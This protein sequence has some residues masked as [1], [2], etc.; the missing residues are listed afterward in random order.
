MRQ[1]VR[2]R[3]IPGLFGLVGMTPVAGV[4]AP[5]CNPLDDNDFLGS[6]SR[7]GSACPSGFGCFGLP[8]FMLATRFTCAPDTTTT[9]TQ[10][11]VCSG[12]CLDT[13]G[14]PLSTGCSE[15]FEPI[16]YDSTGS[17]Q[18]D[19]ISMCAPATCY[20][21]NCGSNSVNLTGAP[22]SGHQCNATDSRGAFNPASPANNGDQC[23]FSW[24]FEVGSQGLVRSPTSDTVGLC[25]D[26]SKYG[27]P[28][29]D[30]LTDPTFGTTANPGAAAF[31]CVSTMVGG[32]PLHPPAEPPRAPYHAR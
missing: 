18:I 9:L 19:C 20:A 1:R 29:C 28:R 12:S 13:G 8:T 26:H 16:I 5:S 11:S 4:C 15:G 6:G 3:R 17:M 31:G 30:T 21:N 24:F 14:N 27:W 2:V 25:L 7:P 23:T 22:A 10:R 32:I